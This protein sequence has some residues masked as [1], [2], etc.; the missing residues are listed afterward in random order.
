[1]NAQSELAAVKPPVTPAAYNE[2][3][4][5]AVLREIRLIKSD[6]SLHPEALGDQKSW[7]HLQSCE[8]QESHY[9]ASDNSLVMFVSAEA[10]C[11]NK[12]KRVIS[13]KC[14]YMVA[15]SVDGKPDEAAVEAFARRVARFSAYPYF[16]AH[17]AQLMS[18]AGVEVPPLPI[19]KERRFIPDLNKAPVAAETSGVQ[20]QLENG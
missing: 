14:R 12:R 10:Y 2:F 5:R 20:K 6:F 17:F 13:T 8:I 11:V 9:D 18:Q 19:I 7:R 1:M 16:R 4:A 15:Y 3:V